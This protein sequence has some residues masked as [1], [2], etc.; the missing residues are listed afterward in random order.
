MVGKSGR[1]WVFIDGRKGVGFFEEGGK[2][3]CVVML[4]GCM[5]MVVDTLGSF[6]F[7]GEIDGS[8]FVPSSDKEYVTLTLIL[9]H[10]YT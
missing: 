9:R 5:E 3:L 7:G 10:E 6:L 2:G 8:D 4:A 1:R